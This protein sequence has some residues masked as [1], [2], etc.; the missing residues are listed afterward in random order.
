MQHDQKIGL[1][2]VI[3]AV[4]DGSIKKK[5]LN[6][7]LARLQFLGWLFSIFSFSLLNGQSWHGFAIQEESCLCLHALI[8]TEKSKAVMYDEF[9]VF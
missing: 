9:F 2:G 3:A 5:H 6:A 7:L 8:G 1:W 4:G